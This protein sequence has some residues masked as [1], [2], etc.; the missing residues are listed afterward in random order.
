[1]A[2]AS[3]A[4]NRNV[5]VFDQPIYF[6]ELQ[7]P[8]R[9]NDLGI[10]SRGTR[11][12]RNGEERNQHGGASATTNLR[13]DKKCRPGADYMLRG[14]HVGALFTILTF[15]GGY[16]LEE[17]KDRWVLTDLPGHP[18]YVCRP[19]PFSTDS[20]RI[21]TQ[22]TD[23]RLSWKHLREPICRVHGLPDGI[24]RIPVEAP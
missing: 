11:K 24:A 19:P 8:V 6:G 21:S 7:M 10:F 5:N 3:I 9:Q 18:A 17:C 1:M 13:R 12:W 20:P 2:G 14:S 22:P 4:R 15:A 16:C 23:N